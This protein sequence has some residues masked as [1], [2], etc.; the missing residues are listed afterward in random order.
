MFRL[1]TSIVIACSVGLS[2]YVVADSPVP[3]Y[4]YK[5]ESE[6]G[7]HVFVMLSPLDEDVEV[8]PFNDEFSAEIL[9][10]RQQ[11]SQSGLYTVD[12]ATVPLWTVD[13][14]AHSVRLF[15]DGVHLVREGPWASS[16]GAEGVSFFANGKL[17]KTYSV[18]DLVFAPWAMPH[19]TSHF[20]WRKDTSIDN[21]GLS[22]HVLTIHHE[23]IQFDARTGRIVRSFSPPGWI[24]IILVVIPAGFVM[25]WRSRRRRSR[26]Q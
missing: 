21:E 3:P 1:L 8:Q 14:Y 15:S 9:K 10:I 7:R 11:Y 19:T 17:V 22:Y 24:L 4:S 5:I 18:S 12:N 6:D 2:S 20:I 23:R 16:A 26:S 13:W 25:M